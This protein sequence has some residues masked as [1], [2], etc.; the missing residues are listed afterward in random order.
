MEGQTDPT[1]ALSFICPKCGKIARDDVI[2]LCNHCKQEDVIERDGVYMCPACLI[3]GDNF[4]CML[5]GSK[6]VTME[7][8][9][10]PVHSIA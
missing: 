3:P 10:P 8:K 2:F 7:T 5:C 1:T 6:Q 4:E 9:L